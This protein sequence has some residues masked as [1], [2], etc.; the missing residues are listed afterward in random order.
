MMKKNRI[1][2]YWKNVSFSIVVV[3]FMSTRFYICFKK[4]F[5]WL[6][7]SS[8]FSM[9]FIMFTYYIYFV[10][11][12]FTICNYVFNNSTG[13]YTK[14]CLRNRTTLPFDFLH[15]CFSS[16]RVAWWLINKNVIF[17]LSLLHFCLPFGFVFIR[18]RSW[19]SWN[20]RILCIKK[21]RFAHRP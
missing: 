21:Q 4:C 11:Y 5:S 2:L 15:L 6:S 8:K 7:W 17:L 20:F 18:M 12:I 9:L 1:L 10:N 19:E 13:L 14:I 16:T 3:L